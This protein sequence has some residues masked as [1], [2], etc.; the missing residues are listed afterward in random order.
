[1]V[2]FP[3]YG[4]TA[5]DDRTEVSMASKSDHAVRPAN[6]ATNIALDRKLVIR[7]GTI[8]HDGL[9]DEIAERHPAVARRRESDKAQQNTASSAKRS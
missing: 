7:G 9:L 3:I 6:A 1:V 2:E 5:A 4:M 8:S